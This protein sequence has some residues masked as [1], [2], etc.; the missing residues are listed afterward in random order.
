M[1]E[2]KLNYFISLKTKNF[3]FI[4]YHLYTMRLNQ[5]GATI[6]MSTFSCQTG[7]R[8]PDQTTRQTITGKMIKKST[9]SMENF[10][11]FLSIIVED[12]K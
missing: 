8:G 4:F 7:R 3:N 12:K 2:K 11:Y 5:L 9:T 1:T 6:K 10:T